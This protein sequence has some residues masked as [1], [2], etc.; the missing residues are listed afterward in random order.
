MFFEYEIVGSLGCRPVDYPRVIEM[1][2]QRKVN[3]EAVVTSTLPLDRIGQAAD[4][5]RRGQGFRT[6]I[7]P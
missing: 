5:L 3:L 6:L 4:D 1:V 2:R 7:I